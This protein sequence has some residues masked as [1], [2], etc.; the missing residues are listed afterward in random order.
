VAVRLLTPGIVELAGTNPD[1]IRREERGY[2]EA[3]LVGEAT[4]DW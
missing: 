4:P 1:L 3:V 2:R